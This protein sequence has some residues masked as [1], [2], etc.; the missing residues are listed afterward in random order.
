[1]IRGVGLYRSY[2]GKDAKAAALLK[3]IARDHVEKSYHLLS[4]PSAVPVRATLVTEGTRV[5]LVEEWENKNGYNEYA[6]MS[7]AIDEA[8][9]PH[10]CSATSRSTDGSMPAKTEFFP[11]ALHICKPMPADDPTIGILVR[12]K[13]ACD[14]NGRK[15]RDVQREAYERQMGLEP[16][17]TCCIILA[18]SE[19]DMSQV[20]IIELW[21][22]EDDFY[23]HETSDWHANG[24][25]KVVP[26]V[27]DM[28]C[29]WVKGYQLRS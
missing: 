9:K 25:E 29:D 16:G 22:T 12:Q 20:R 19:E 4:P 14:E 10:I 7:H 23:F 13:T 11:E 17:C 1:M 21:K 8:V 5:V 15:L 27:V 26:L 6:G 3:K 24:E 18:S 2:S 28:D